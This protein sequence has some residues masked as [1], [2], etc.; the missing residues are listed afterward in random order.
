MKISVRF[1]KSLSIHP[2]NQFFLE[3]MNWRYMFDITWNLVPSISNSV[4]E[5]V[6]SYIQSTSF[7]DNVQLIC[8]GSS[9]SN[10]L[11]S[12][13]ILYKSYITFNIPNFMDYLIHLHD[14]KHNSAFLQAPKFQ[15]LKFT[16]IISGLDAR[17][18]S[19]CFALYLF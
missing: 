5:K 6:L 10:T 15:L 9:C 3:F 7:L 13:S 16:W 14:I 11:S 17:Y 18:N 4:G 1:S 19:N 8:L 2:I 12:G